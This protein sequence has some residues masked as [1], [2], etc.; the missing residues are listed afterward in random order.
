MSSTFF[1]FFKNFFALALAP[2][3]RAYV[4]GRFALALALALALDRGKVFRQA[5]THESCTPP[6]WY[7]FLTK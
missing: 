7:I 6:T 5:G 4:G 3:R 2:C 1:D